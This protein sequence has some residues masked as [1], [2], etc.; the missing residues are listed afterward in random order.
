M[1]KADVNGIRYNYEAIGNGEPIVLICGF[2]GSL[3]FWKKA[4][5]FLS[6]HYM[7]ISVDNRGSGLTECNLHFSIDDMA[8]DISGLLDHLSIGSAHIVGWSLGSNVAQMFAIRHP[9]KVRTLILMSTYLY[10]P[11]R[12]AYLL[13]AA[14]FAV[15][16]GAPEECFGRILNGLTY[17]ESFFKMKEEDNTPIKIVEMNDIRKLRSQL[18]AVD[19]FDTSS[20]ASNILAPTLCIHGTED[21]MVEIIEG[22]RTC[23]AIH[24]CQMR[25]LKGEGHNLPS[26]L[27]VP[28]IMD[29]IE[30][31][32]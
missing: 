9:E 7:V 27:Y 10:R 11:S 28:I 21:I 26:K 17:T 18:D 15:E 25:E 16:N 22:T 24:D 20:S 6:Q 1:P 13:D 8:D 5:D 14:L 19:R 31:H 4:A 32:R 2:G 29:F 3:N 23:D 30:S 12:S